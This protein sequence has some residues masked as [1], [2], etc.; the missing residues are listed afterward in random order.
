MLLT[1]NYPLTNSHK[2]IE[3]YNLIIFVQNTR[4]I[5]IGIGLNLANENLRQK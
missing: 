3:I 4:L 1:Y 2:R 5:P